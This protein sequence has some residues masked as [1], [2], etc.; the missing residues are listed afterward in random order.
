[1][2]GVTEFRTFQEMVDVLALNTPHA[3]ILDW[4]R[5]VDRGIDYYFRARDLRRP[6]SRAEVEQ[7][8]A[9]DANLGDEVAAQVRKLREFRNAVAH[10]PTKSISV[11]E[12]A[13]Y[14]QT[15]LNLVWQIATDPQEPPSEEWPLPA[16]GLNCTGGH[17]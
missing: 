5:R 9:S 7:R 2:A 3:L 16:S 6:M 17:T 1:M 14:A 11:E 4:G 12:A 8:L 13:C 10:E 15:A